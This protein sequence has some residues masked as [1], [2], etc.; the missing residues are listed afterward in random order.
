MGTFYRLLIADYLGIKPTCAS[1]LD[2]GC[3]D[4]YFLSK[5]RAKLKVGLD[6]EPLKKYMNVEMVAADGFHLP[7]IATFDNI[8][9]FDVVEHI[10]DYVSFTLSLV[11]A[12]SENGVL[13]LS[14]PSK[15]I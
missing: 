10:K 1:V 14:T 6:L 5:V 7:F 11:G 13:I 4:G 15:R 12:L 3:Y 9:A 2:V 8:F